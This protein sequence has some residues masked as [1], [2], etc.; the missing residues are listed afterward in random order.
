[1]IRTAKNLTTQITLALLAML[2]MVC[3]VY[4]A[5]VDRVQLKSSAT[6]DDNLIQ[7]REIAYLTGDTAQKLGGS[8]V[9]ELKGSQAQTRITLRMVNKHLSGMGV[10]WGRLNLTGAANC[11]VQIGDPVS[12]MTQTTVVSNPNKTITTDDALTVEK[13]VEN[14][15]LQY[16]GYS[17]QELVVKYSSVDKR[18]LQ[19]PALMD[20]FEIQVIGSAKLGRLPLTIGRWRG[21]TLVSQ[22]RVTA[23][24]SYKTLALVAI[25]NIRRGDQFGPGDLQVQEVELHSDHA[26]PL[27]KLSEVVGLIASRSIRKKQTLLVDDVRPALVIRRGQMVS[28][29]TIVGG[30]VIRTTARAMA[31]AAM[32]QMIQ[33]KNERSRE[34]F[35]ARVIG[36]R[37]AV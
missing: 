20:R 15:L 36:P 8:V 24:V 1:M 14:F 16:T 13:Q 18:Q 22:T 31:D 28:I 4:A 12:V 9:V 19:S 7:L 30:M 33:L 5:S 11:Q 32:D 6:S 35:M 23:K 27:R 17:D 21:S 29:R 2:V 37:A 3:P 34:S 26:K 10:N 25:N